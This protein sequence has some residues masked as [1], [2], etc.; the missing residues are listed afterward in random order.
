MDSMPPQQQ[1]PLAAPRTPRY[2]GLD[3]GNR[4]IGVALSDPLN[5]TAQ[6]VLTL[7]RKNPRED[8]RSLARLLRRHGCTAIVAGNPLHMSGLAGT[9][10]AKAQAFAEQLGHAANV[11]VHLYD[12]RLT[13]LEAHHILSEAGHPR[14]QHRRLV[15]QVAAVLILQGFL[16]T[17]PQPQHL[18]P[19]PEGQ[20]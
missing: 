11:P 16:D 14:Q 3:I 15:D 5:L 8:I 18:P 17:L 12:E 6:P 4:R 1:P 2:L 7:Y 13:T 19:H 20:V 10:A 9:Q